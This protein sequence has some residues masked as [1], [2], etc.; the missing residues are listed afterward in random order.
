LNKGT[1]WNVIFLTTPKDN[2]VDD[3]ER[4]KDQA[5]LEDRKGNY[6]T[7]KEIINGLYPDVEI[8]EL[9]GNYEENFNIVKE[10]IEKIYMTS[11][12]EIW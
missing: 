6:E 10:Y 2:F 8:I 9:D 7:L 1:K 5:S 3:G 12:L 4:N 11:G